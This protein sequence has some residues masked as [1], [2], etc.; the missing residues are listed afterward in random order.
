MGLLAT[1]AGVAFT[2]VM[3][4]HNIDNPNFPQTP[5]QRDQYMILPSI[6][7]LPREKPPEK[8]KLGAN[9]SPKNK[10]PHVGPHTGP[11][12]FT[13]P[14]FYRPSPRSNKRPFVPA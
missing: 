8:I 11:R 12:D 13:D 14:S 9:T 1:C 4:M 7:E 2:C 5:W 3:P 10:P 6:P